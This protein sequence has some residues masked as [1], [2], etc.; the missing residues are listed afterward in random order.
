MNSSL[1]RMFKVI[2]SKA[3]G[4]WVAVSEIVRA[5][6]KEQ[7]LTR[8]TRHFAVVAVM[9]GGAAIAAPP[10]APNQ[11]PTGGQIAIR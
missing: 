8:I 2:W 11:L 4:A 5:H 7:S 10:P 6:G 1:N 9:S 3:Q